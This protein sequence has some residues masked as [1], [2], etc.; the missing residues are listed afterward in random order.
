MNFKFKNGF[1]AWSVGHIFVIFLFT[2]NTRDTFLNAEVI[3]GNFRAIPFYFSSISNLTFLKA[4][5][6]ALSVC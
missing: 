4:P 5:S 6:A 3:S 1:L 2:L